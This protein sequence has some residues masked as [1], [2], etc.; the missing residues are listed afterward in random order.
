MRDARR[1][2]ATMDARD[3]KSTRQGTSKEKLQVLIEIRKS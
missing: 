1:L 2:G 3:D